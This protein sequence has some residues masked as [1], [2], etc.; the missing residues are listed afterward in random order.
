LA[1]LGRNVADAW[2]DACTIRTVEELHASHLTT[3]GTLIKEIH[4]PDDGCPESNCWVMPK[5]WLM[6]NQMG[7]MPVDEWAIDSEPKLPAL[8]IWSP[9]WERL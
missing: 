8:L 6:V 4:T 9:D 1:Y 5:L 3:W 7:W 2:R